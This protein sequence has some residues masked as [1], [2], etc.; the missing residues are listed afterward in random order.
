MT[1]D[2]TPIIV[3]NFLFMKKTLADEVDRAGNRSQRKEKNLEGVDPYNRRTWQK[4]IKL[5]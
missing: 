5:C 1:E 4:P 2:K 3:K